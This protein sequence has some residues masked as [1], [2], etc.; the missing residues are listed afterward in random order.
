MYKEQFAITKTIGN[1]ETVIRYFGVTE[2]DSACRA[3]EEIA[4]FNTEGVIACVLAYFDQ[5][6]KMKDGT[7]R[8]FSV[9]D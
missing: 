4:K 6:G 9:W 2:K 5:R 3:G 1:E 8:V 7:C